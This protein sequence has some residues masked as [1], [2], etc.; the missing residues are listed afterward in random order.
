MA[1]AEQ[2]RAALEFMKDVMW[3]DLM[4]VES[5]RKEG[6]LALQA[7][8]LRSASYHDNVIDQEAGSISIILGGNSDFG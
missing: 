8:G 5:R 3:L 7:A 4:V 6:I 1:V 2:K